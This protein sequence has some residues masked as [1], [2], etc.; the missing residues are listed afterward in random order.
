[1]EA[2]KSMSIFLHIRERLW[3]KVMI[4]LAGV[5]ITVFGAILL[6]N[7]R[8][9]TN[10][11]QNQSRFSSNVLATAIE[12]G[13]FDALAIGDNDSV[14]GQ[15]KR[16]KEKVP[17]LKVHIFDFNRQVAFTTDSE[18]LGRDVE[19]MIQNSAAVQAVDQMLQTGESPP[20]AFEETVNGASYLSVFQ[21]ILNESRCFHCHGSARE[22]LGA[23]RLPLLWRA[24]CR[25]PV[26]HEI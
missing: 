1:M 23:F 17:G 2:G 11:I 16:L 14:R 7:L 24:P 12:G 4:A 19:S 13:M 6:I 10:I 22:V 5:V 26:R 18:S 25:Q 15:L 8:N 20:E 21:P 3:A 9:Q